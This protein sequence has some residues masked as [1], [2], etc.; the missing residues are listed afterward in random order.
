MV[1]SVYGV[2]LEIGSYHV[3]LIVSSSAET[4]TKYDVVNEIY[5]T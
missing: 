2:C 3:N 5:S 1:Y 4:H